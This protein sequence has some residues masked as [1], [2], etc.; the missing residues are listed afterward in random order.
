[1]H[2]RWLLDH[3]VNYFTINN[4]LFYW[5]DKPGAY[6]SDRV[7][8]YGLRF[9]LIG[10]LNA[11]GAVCLRET[12]R[13]HAQ[14]VLIPSHIKYLNESSVLSWIKKT[15]NTK[16]GKDLVDWSF[17]DF[18]TKFY[19]INFAYFILPSKRYKKYISFAYSF[20][21]I[22]KNCVGKLFHWVECFGNKI[23]NKRPD[24]EERNVKFSIR[25]FML[26]ER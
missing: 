6:K 21:L 23:V 2:Q 22:K 5:K 14:T 20:V 8:I 24:K 3:S 9:I 7:E 11:E 18:V 4:N 1:M 25:T 26:S 15:Y 10:N 17:I 12:R 19:W 16:L 13:Y